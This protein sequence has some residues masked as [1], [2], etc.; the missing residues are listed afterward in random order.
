M[1]N[2][3]AALLYPKHNAGATQLN[4]RVASASAVCRLLNSQLVHDE[5]GRKIENWTCW[6]FVQIPT[7]LA[8][9]FETGSRLPTGE[10][11]PPD[12]TQLDSTVDMFGF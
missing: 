8:A 9:E 12:T 2:H 4:S 10:Y 1:D 5:F 11:T 7:E 3:V 6:E